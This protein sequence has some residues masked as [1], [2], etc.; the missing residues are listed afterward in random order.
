MKKRIV[1][2]VALMAMLFSLMPMKALAADNWQSQVYEN[3][4]VLSMF[5]IPTQKITNSYVDEAGNTCFV[6]SYDKGVTETVIILPVSGDKHSIVIE[7]DGIR[8][9]ATIDATGVLY[10][11]GCKVVSVRSTGTYEQNSTRARYLW[12]DTAPPFGSTASDY[13]YVDY[14]FDNNVLLTAALNTLSLTII[15]IVIGDICPFAGAALSLATA[16]YGVAQAYNISTYGLS[17]KEKN[18][19]L[20]NPPILTTVYKYESTWYTGP[21]LTGHSDTEVYYCVS[22]FC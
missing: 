20:M 4:D 6:M 10:V 1:S 3:R 9:E 2:V 11:D 16:I 8:N 14:T 19:V 13:A 12:Y 7:G 15:D 18:Y 5:R 17:Y 21:N 22:E